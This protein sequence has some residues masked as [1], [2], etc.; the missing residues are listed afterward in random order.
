MDP[1]QSLKPKLRAFL[2]QA[3]V[4]GEAGDKVVAYYCK[5]HALSEAMAIRASIPKADMGY[6]IGLMD[7]V[8]GEKKGLDL[9]DAQFQE[10]SASTNV[11]I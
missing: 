4:R 6:V 3:K 7:E 8:E 11:P 5:V 1:P 9:D 2:D 10:R